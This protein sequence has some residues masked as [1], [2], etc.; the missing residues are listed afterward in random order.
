MALINERLE[1]GVYLSYRPEQLPCM[2]QWKVG[3]TGEYV[4]AFEPGNCH[5]IGR[6]E[7]KKRGGQEILEPMEKHIVDLEIGILDG[8]EEI[9]E[10][11]EKLEKLIGGEERG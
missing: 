5:P 8:P 9:R 3:R 11:K 7:Q 2:A 4:F 6:A 1:L 10:F